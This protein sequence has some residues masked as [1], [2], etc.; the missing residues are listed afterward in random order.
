MTQDNKGDTRPDNKAVSQRVV[1]AVAGARDVDPLEL[2]P[3]YNVIDPDV[4][5]QIVD[6]G[7]SGRRSGSGRVVFTMA[8]CEVSV[9]SDGAVEVTAPGNRDS[10]SSVT[11]HTNV[12]DEGE[13]TLD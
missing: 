10:S 1:A 3:I 2:P 9:H 13:T 8:S 6:H 5:N 7:V 12:R 11:G 4:L